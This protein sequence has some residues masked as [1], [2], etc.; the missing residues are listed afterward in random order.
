MAESGLFRRSIVFSR[1]RDCMI[2]ISTGYMADGEGMS[3]PLGMDPIPYWETIVWPLNDDGSKRRMIEGPER[4]YDEGEAIS[5]H[6]KFTSKYRPVAN[7]GERDRNE[8][9][10]NGDSH[11]S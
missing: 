1:E 5:Q 8:T 11:G 7:Q 10:P 3:F 9:D 6:E 4:C 2:L